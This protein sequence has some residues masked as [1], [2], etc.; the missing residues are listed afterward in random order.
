MVHLSENQIEAVI[1]NSV[2]VDKCNYS[3]FG[4]HTSAGFQ[5]SLLLYLKRKIDYIVQVYIVD[6]LTQ[7][8]VTC[9]YVTHIKISKLNMSLD[10][11]KP[12]LE[13]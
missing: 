7:K 1:V 11:K 2:Q 6:W 5:A 8:W 10:F 12:V 4:G 13:K 9:A 3:F